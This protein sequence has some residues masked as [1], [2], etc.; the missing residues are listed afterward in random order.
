MGRDQLVS[1]IMYGCLRGIASAD[2]QYCNISCGMCA[3]GWGGSCA[4][5]ANCSIGSF[6][7]SDPALKKWEQG[8]ILAPGRS[9]WNVDIS[10][11]RPQS[12]GSKT[13]V[14]AIEQQPL[15]GAPAG[16][17]EMQLSIVTRIAPI[18]FPAAHVQVHDLESIGISLYTTRL[19]IC[20]LRQLITRAC[21]VVMDFLFLRE[22]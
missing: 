19:L 7:T 21:R 18:F 13:Y 4:T 17:Q 12:D 11:G 1:H 9:S 15:A 10:T 6:K 2:A 5:N 8:Q 16:Q 14:L 20:H 22:R 3:D